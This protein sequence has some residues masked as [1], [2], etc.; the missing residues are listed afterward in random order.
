M[1]AQASSAFQSDGG[2]LPPVVAAKG[3]LSAPAVAVLPHPTAMIGKVLTACVRVRVIAV[4]IKSQTAN[5]GESGHWISWIKLSGN[6]PHFQ[7]A[8]LC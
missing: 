5:F 2:L 8:A 1:A 6:A 4:S 7:S 3:P